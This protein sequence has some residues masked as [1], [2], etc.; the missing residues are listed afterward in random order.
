MALQEREEQL[1]MSFDLYLG[2]T[3]SG[4]SFWSL[5]RNLGE[6][7]ALAM[8]ILMRPRLDRKRLKTIQGQYIDGMRRRYDYPDYGVYLVENHV[9]NHDHPRLG[10]EASR[11][12]IQAVT[13]D[14]VRKI[15]RRYLG[16]DNL[17]VTVVGDFDK[18]E[19]LDMIQQTFS[20][21][22]PAEDKRREFITRDPV[23]R[24]GLY[25]VE[26]EVSAPAVSLTHQIRVDRTAPLEDHAAIEILNDILGGSDFRS[27]LMERLRSDEGLTYG[28]Y[29][30][31]GHDGRPGT[32]GQVTISYE[33]KKVSI[34]RSIASVVE[35]FQKMALGK[36]SQAEVQEQ[37]DAWRNRFVFRFTNEF[38]SVDRLMELEL[39]DRPYDYERTLLEAVQKVTP[40]D[41]ERVAKKY[42][43]PESLTICV[44]GT[45]T[46]E[47]R[48]TL[49]ERYSL[50]L[51][52][53]SEVF[54]G[55]YE[56]A[57]ETKHKWK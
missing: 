11:K 18:K 40:A 7:F 38:Y 54:R 21:W 13:S 24:P 33:T 39:D 44:F 56:E 12:E 26:K 20:S 1:G 10:Y 57:E 48:K 35:E 16:R 23:I 5:K 49:G 29:S 27:R 34:A 42:L 8:D 36:V 52:P 45:L 14:S 17:Y 43:A 25:L 19:I 6:S 9:I 3:Q 55:G 53:R 32:P 15:W 46:D 2:S 4:A 47:D 50:T 22:R 30:S 51:L 28:I 37:I 41:V 31:L